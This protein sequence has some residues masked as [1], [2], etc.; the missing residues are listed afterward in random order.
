MGEKNAEPNLNNYKGIYFDDDN[1]KFTCPITGAHFRFEEM[2]KILEKVRIARGDTKVEFDAQK[3]ST[4]KGR[5]DTE[6]SSND[7]PSEAIITDR[8]PV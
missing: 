4:R 7:I 1:E 6:E 3:K 8:V 5:L 2:C